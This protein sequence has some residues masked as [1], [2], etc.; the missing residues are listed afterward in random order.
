MRLQAQTDASSFA[1][2]EPTADGFRNYYRAGQEQS[3]IH[4]A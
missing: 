2:L 4:D 1:F 3:P